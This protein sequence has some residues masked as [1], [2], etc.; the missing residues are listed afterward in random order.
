MEVDVEARKVTVGLKGFPSG[1]PPFAL[2]DADM[3]I[4]AV[5]RVRSLRV[6]KV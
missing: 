1:S 4:Q 6:N 3:A 2:N 5:Y